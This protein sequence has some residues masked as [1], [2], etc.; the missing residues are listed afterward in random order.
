MKKIPMLFEYESVSGSKRLEV[1]KKPNPL[2]QWVFDN[3]GV[4]TRKYDG[5]C[6]CT[7]GVFNF[8][9]RRSVKPTMSR[10]EEFIKV[11]ED[12]NTGILY[13]WV[14]V[15]LLD[16]S[17][18]YHWEA[19][20][21]L[22]RIPEPG[23]YELCGPKINWNPEKMDHHVLIKHSESEIYHN[24][25][26]NYD[27]LKVWLSDRDIEGLVFHHPDGRMAKIRK[28]DFGLKR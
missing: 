1:T 11:S 18:Q 2:C 15:S 17:D 16:R 20:R 24:V 22:E 14:P 6:C 8:F 25:P 23:T 26:R 3:E 4:A 27:D 5:E 10:P 28:K 21:R 7:D 12:Q 19:W 9:K 13:G